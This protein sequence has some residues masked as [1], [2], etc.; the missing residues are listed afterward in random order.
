LPA[1]RGPLFHIL[2]SDHRR[3]HVLPD[4]A[5]RHVNSGR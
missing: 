3:E 2:E 5:A 1:G 4:H